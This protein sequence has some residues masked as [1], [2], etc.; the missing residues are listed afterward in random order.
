[1][2]RLSR[3]V[4]VAILAFTLPAPAGALAAASPSGRRVAAIAPVDRA[5]TDT[6]LNAEYEL[7]KAT[8]ATIRTI[9]AV[10]ARAA[11]ELSHECKGVLD[12]VPD[13]SVIEEEGPSASEPRLSGRAPITA[14]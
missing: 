3:W 9:G 13:G 4:I 11:E 2:V 6:L 10:E 1:M 12:G 7:A 5:A 14:G 8:Q